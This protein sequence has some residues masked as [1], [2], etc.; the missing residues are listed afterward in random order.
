MLPFIGL[1]LSAAWFWVCY[2]IVTKDHNA[3]WLTMILWVVL[4]DFV[5]LPFMLIA[6][7]LDN[8]F[9]AFTMVVLGIL[10]MCAVLYIILTV[11]YH[12]ERP[13]EKWAVLGLFFG[14]LLLPSIFLRV[15]T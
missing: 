13:R 2:V 7:G 14:G 6:E 4:A 3:N 8:R 9:Y 12:I 10:A 5:R 1:F 11:K 15:F